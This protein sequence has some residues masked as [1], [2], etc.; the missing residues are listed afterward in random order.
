M[1]NSI[2]HLWLTYKLY[3]EKSRGKFSNYDSAELATES[4][5]SYLE[6]INNMVDIFP[7]WKDNLDSILQN[8]VR[9][10]GGMIECYDKPVISEAKTEKT[11][12]SL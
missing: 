3:Y 12:W 9:I 1:N 4:T 5:N 10:I 2:K 8:Q 6:Y 7:E 11:R